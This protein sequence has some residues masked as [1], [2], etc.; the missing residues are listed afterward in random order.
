MCLIW[1]NGGSGG[2]FSFSIAERR[3]CQGVGHGPGN[4]WQDERK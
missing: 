2:N 1:R 3:L 4:K